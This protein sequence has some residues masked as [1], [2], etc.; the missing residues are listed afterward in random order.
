VELNVWIGRSCE[1]RRYIYESAH[2]TN[3]MTHAI[4]ASIQI[5]IARMSEL[6]RTRGAH[7]DTPRG[8]KTV[9]R[10]QDGSLSHASG[11]AAIKTAFRNVHAATTPTND[12]ARVMPIFNSFQKACSTQSIRSQAGPR[13]LIEPEL[14]LH[15]TRIVLS[16]DSHDPPATRACRTTF[17]AI[18]S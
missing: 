13:L 1:N 18:Q 15:P 10:S 5:P 6:P 9:T 12:H 8:N 2:W 7:R 11:K 17:E 16:S 4:A 3:R 14:L